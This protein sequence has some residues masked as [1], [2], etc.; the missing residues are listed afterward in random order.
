MSNLRTVPRV[1]LLAV[2]SALLVVACVGA[3]AP[4]RSPSASSSPVAIGDGLVDTPEE[5]IAA[6]VAHDPR[7]AT[8]P[9]YRA[10]LIG[11]SAWYKVA[12]ASGVGAYVVEV[13]VGWG[14]CPAG[15]IDRHTWIFAILPDGTVNQQSETG[16]VVPPAQWPSPSAGG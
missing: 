1:V 4:A 5:A 13:Q 12:A 8:I 6:V 2:A 15:C 11:Q 10:D 16:A 14:D 9:P 3:G 7:F